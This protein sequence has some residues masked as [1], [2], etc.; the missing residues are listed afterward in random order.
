MAEEAVFWVDE[1]E[2]ELVFRD[3]EGE[4]RY[5]IE[6]EVELDGNKYLVISPTD[7]DDEDASGTILK[8]VRDGD[9]DALVLIDNDD[10][11]E[12]ARQAYIDSFNET[13]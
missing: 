8:L 12:R 5:L 3:E 4:E 11:F 1:N 7:P 13:E 2:G 6:K 9:E 10:E